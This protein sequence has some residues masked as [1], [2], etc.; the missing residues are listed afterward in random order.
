[1]SILV[2][3]R[4][5]RSTAN[6]AGVLAGRTPG[7]LLDDIGRRQVRDTAHRLEQ[8]PL[9]RVVSSPLERTRQTAEAILENRDTP[10]TTDS[11]LTEC[12][13]GTWQNRTL[14]ELAE[15]DLWKVVTSR[16]SAAAFPGGESMIDM[17]ARAVDAVARHHAA[18]EEE[19][20]DS[21]VWA[22]VS[23]GDIIKAVI[24]DA[25]GMPFDNFQRVHVDPASV[26]VIRY[27]RSTPQVLC[28]NTTAGDLSW[29]SGDSSTAPRVGGGA[30]H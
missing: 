10:L 28:V 29:L 24:A 19:S 8:V 25:Y 20:G 27:T 4:H 2:L 16:P 30:G 1:M 22:V 18:V 14:R 5:G 6:T 13:Y 7:V 3:V 23:H 17:R 26:T 12:D 11:A 9:A 21:A 15:E